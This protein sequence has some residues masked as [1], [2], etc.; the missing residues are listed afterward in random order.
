[1]SLANGAG[2]TFVARGTAYHLGS[3]DR[4]IVEAMR[5]KGF[6]VVEIVNSC[7]TAFGK[8]NKFKTPIDLLTWMK[9]FFIPIEAFGK[10]P[11]EKTEGKLP[12]GV[13]Y[14]KEGAPEFCE[15]YFA[16]VSGLKDKEKERTGKR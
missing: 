1:P 14:K 7:P 2:A 3:L 5:H 6:S 12:I 13:L 11:P 4:L 15:A 16:M 8:R 9:D 10:L